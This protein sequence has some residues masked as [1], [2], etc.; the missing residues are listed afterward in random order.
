MLSDRARTDRAPTKRRRIA[1]GPLPPV[2]PSPSGG[3]LSAA[4]RCALQASEKPRLSS[5]S[6]T[7]RDLL[8]V[9][10][11]ALA[12]TSQARPRDHRPTSAKRGTQ[13]HE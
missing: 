4:C 5:R 2:R 11:A 9:L 6:C 12:T 3:L 7:A 10:S 13:A 8:S 1:C